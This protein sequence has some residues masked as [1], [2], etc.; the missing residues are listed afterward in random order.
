M[1][2]RD[3][4]VFIAF[5]AICITLTGARSWK[6]I[7]FILHQSRR[8]DLPQDAMIREQETNLQT[9]ES[10]LSSLLQMA[11][12]LWDWRFFGALI[13]G[14]KLR[15]SRTSTWKV[16]FLAFAHTLVFISCGIMAPTLLSSGGGSSLVQADSDVCALWIGSNEQHAESV[17]QWGSARAKAILA[18]QNY[19]TNCYG[20]E[21][22][23]ICNLL[24]HRK[25]PWEEYE[26]ECPFSREACLPDSNAFVL[27]T[28]P[29]HPSILGANSPM[30][31]SLSFRKRLT[32]IP[33]D[34]SLYEYR[35]DDS[36]LRYNLSTTF[37]ENGPGR[38]F[39]VSF[40]ND[41]KKTDY[42]VKQ[43]Y[44]YDGDET[45]LHDSLNGLPA[46]VTIIVL[47][48]QGI[49]SMDPIDDPIFAAHW[50]MTIFVPP[51]GSVQIYRA[52]SPVTMLGCIDQYEFCNI[53]KN[54]C[55]GLHGYSESLDPTFL[56]VL[57]LD[58]DQWDVFTFIGMVILGMGVESI[59]I[60]RGPEIL[61][62]RG[63]YW[64]DN[65]IQLQLPKD[66]WKHKA[67]H[68]FATCLAKLQLTSLAASIGPFYHENRSEFTNHLDTFSPSRRSFF[69][70][71]ILFRSSNHTT[72]N[73]IVLLVI[74]VMSATIWILS[75]SDTALGRWMFTR[76]PHKV[77]A[78][79][80]DSS[81][82]LPRQIHEHLRAGVWISSIINSYPLANGILGVPELVQENGSQW[83]ARL[84]TNPSVDKSLFELVDRLSGK[85]PMARNELRRR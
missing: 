31:N 69:C 60:S 39:F 16:L 17:S 33:L 54:R 8:H 20:E 66:Q 25:V 52:D 80:L 76:W 38:D 29:M 37:L 67:R 71:N 2:T 7:R 6:I 22:L 18:A 79:Q 23:G 57:D 85:P 56:T 21:S 46:D 62:A 10:D 13:P 63:E 59:T 84:T 32:C 9:S 68:W 42:V 35:T 53:R 78:W 82:H 48:K 34:H 1:T 26:D 45:Y 64:G 72:M 15:N 74:L 77:L 11:R 40:K 27:D 28:G 50:P 43:L 55:T 41:S 24:A 73:F 5:I 83:Q 19:Y 51:I 12:L 49:Y 30:G 58:D 70:H 47:N 44:K 36:Y 61:A 75:F 81:R 4:F 3:A 14:G 65:S